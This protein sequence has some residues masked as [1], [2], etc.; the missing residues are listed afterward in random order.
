MIKGVDIQTLGLRRVLMTL[1]KIYYVAFCKTSKRLKALDYF[2]KKFHPIWMFFSPYT[3]IYR[4]DKIQNSSVI[5][6]VKWKKFESRY[7][8]NHYSQLL[9]KRGKAYEV[10][11]KYSQRHE[12]NR[13]YI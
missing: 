7:N 6:A 9:S 5:W 13:S 8:P 11:S 3:G 4:P 2:C 10:I 12:C 1:S